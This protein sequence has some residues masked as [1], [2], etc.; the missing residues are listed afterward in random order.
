MSAMTSDASANLY[1][2]FMICRSRLHICDATGNE[3]DSKVLMFEGCSEV[4]RGGV[5]GRSSAGKF[6]NKR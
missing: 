4:T 5:T 3:L 1:I 6:G 2:D